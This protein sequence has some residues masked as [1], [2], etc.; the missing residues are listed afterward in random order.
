MRKL[1]TLLLGTLIIISL[2]G[3][4]L[5]EDKYP[6]DITRKCVVT[7]DGSAKSKEMIFDRMYKSFWRI[8]KKRTR[9]LEI[10]LKSGFEKGGLYLCWAERPESWRLYDGKE[11]LAQ[12]DENGFFH[13]FVPVSGEHSTLRLEISAS[14]KRYCG[15][16]ELF[17]V[18]GEE[19]PKWVQVWQP[20][21]EKADIMVVAAH[22]DDELLFM[23]GTIPYYTN[24]EKRPM[25]ICYLTMAN[26]M[27]R[28]EMLN[29]LWRMGVKN[30]PVIGKFRDIA[31]RSKSTL[32]QKWGGKNKANAFMVEQFRKFQPKVVVSHDVNGEYGH[33]AHMIA[34]ELV[35]YAAK[36]SSKASIFK[37]SAD[38]YGTHEI[39]KL[40]LHLYP[41]HK[42]QLNWQEKYE[43]LEGLSPLELAGE[44]FKLHRSQQKNHHMGKNRLYNTEAFGLAFTSVGPDVNKNNFFENVD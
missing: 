34:A 40:Y 14:E 30:Y 6:G 7:I 25:V 3:Q 36:N 18:E 31:T 5:L 15:L 29:G 20:T 37:A 32:Y 41:K 17:I 4:S 38:K 24:I 16:S 11:L 9:N 21:L 22:P 33:R 19:T 39:S 12:N 44:A 42:I 35:Q 8:E 2:A 23:G 1:F 28:S 27:R 26:N 10:K 43:E 13:E